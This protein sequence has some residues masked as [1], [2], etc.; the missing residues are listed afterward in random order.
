MIKERN[1]HWFKKPRHGTANEPQRSSL[2]ISFTTK[3]KKNQLS[4][5]WKQVSK[6]LLKF[7]K[8]NSTS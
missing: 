5:W 4:S 2:T 7:F 1:F 8:V 3:E 6:K